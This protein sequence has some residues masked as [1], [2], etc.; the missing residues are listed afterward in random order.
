MGFDEDDN[1]DIEDSNEF[2]TK[3]DEKNVRRPSLVW[4]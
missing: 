2:N 3:G 1:D 4:K